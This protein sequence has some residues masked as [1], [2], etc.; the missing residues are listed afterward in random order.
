M[1]VD[2]FWAGCCGAVLPGACDQE[3]RSFEG[4][5]AVGVV[6]SC[7]RK[8][9]GEVRLRE[10][11]FWNL[12]LAKTY[13]TSSAPRNHKLWETVG[14]GERG[15]WR[16]GPFAPSPGPSY[17]S[18]GIRDTRQPTEARLQ[19]PMDGP[20]APYQF[21][22]LRAALPSLTIAIWQV[23]S[24]GRRRSTM[25][26]DERYRDILHQRAVLWFVASPHRA[27]C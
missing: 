20:Q 7:P 27:H 12:S 17:G 18:D 19:G 4:G 25:L 23:M 9:P 10:S 22:L 16:N 5:I 8:V 2:L 1:G 15:Q 26:D 3:C 13:P 6:S 21:T 24:H 11:S 14:D